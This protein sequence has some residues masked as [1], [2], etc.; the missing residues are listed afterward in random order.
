V[1]TSADHRE[2]ALVQV[3]QTLKS[4]IDLQGPLYLERARVHAMLAIAA[5]IEEHAQVL[6]AVGGDQ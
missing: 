2:A 5:A 4:T 1:L 3:R 6:R